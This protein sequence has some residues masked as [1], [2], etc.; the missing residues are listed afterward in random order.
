MQL[1]VPPE[2][3]RITCELL[4]IYELWSGLLAG[5]RLLGL[6]MDFVIASFDCRCGFRQVGTRIMLHGGLKRIF[7]HH[8]GEQQAE[9]PP[10]I[11][12]SRVPAAAALLRA[13]QCFLI[14]YCN[15]NNCYGDRRK[16][17]RFGL[18]WLA[19]CAS[20]AA[21]TCCNRCPIHILVL[22]M[23]LFCVMLQGCS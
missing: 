15:C 23:A 20:N 3:V 22:Y 16:S 9:A 13:P 11:A 17:A 1:T 8:I 14:V 18:Q 7:G 5:H 10:L 6:R 12:G 4:Q 19:A 2:E 21:A